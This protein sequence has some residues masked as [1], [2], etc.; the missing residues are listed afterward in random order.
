MSDDS[1]IKVWLKKVDDR[2]QNSLCFILERTLEKLNKI[3]QSCTNLVMAS[4][5]E[6]PGQTSLLAI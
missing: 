6:N 1:S 3:D 2:M 5:D 4:I